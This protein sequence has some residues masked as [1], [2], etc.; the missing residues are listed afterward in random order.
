MSRLPIL[1]TKATCLKIYNSKFPMR[2][3]PNLVKSMLE[4]VTKTS[5]VVDEWVEYDIHGQKE[6]IV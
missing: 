3:Q 4:E 2:V 6:M 5:K 1:N